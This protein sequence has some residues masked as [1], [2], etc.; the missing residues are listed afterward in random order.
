M[1]KSIVIAIVLLV[2]TF[3]ISFL[4]NQTFNDTKSMETKIAKELNT[5]EVSIFGLQDND[6]YR[7]IGF[8]FNNDYGFAVF[9]Q[10]EN[11]DYI[12]ERIKKA[13]R[14]IPRA[15]DIVVAYHDD[16]WI[17]L[18]NNKNLNTIKF[19]IMDKLNSDEKI[20]TVEVTDNPSISVIKLPNE[21]YNG[22][23]NFYD[24]KSYLIK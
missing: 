17:A 20:I 13:D 21:D 10:N 2:V 12:F 6:K 7:F 3:L 1:K 19:K 18:S 14:M 11:G 15:L 23:Y 22:E 8:T 4:K 9:K 5:K 16:Y 24:D